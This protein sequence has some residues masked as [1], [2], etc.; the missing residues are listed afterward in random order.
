MKKY[1]SS[2]IIT[3]IIV[4]LT[5]VVGFF[6][7]REINAKNNP[8][9]QTAT[10]APAAGAPAGSLAGGAGAQAGQGT[11]RNATTVRVTP[12]ELGV[13]ENSVIINGDVL[14]SY[15]ISLYPAV[16]GRVTETRYQVGDSVNQGAVVAMV[17]PSRPGEVYSQSQVVSTIS[18]TVLSAPIHPGDTVSANSAVYVVGDLSTLIVETFVPERFSNSAQR[19]LTA[20]V[21]LEALPGETFNAVVDE[22]SPVLDPLSRTLRIRLRFAGR[23]DSR[24]KAGMF[25]TISL[26]TNT[27]QNVPVIPRTAMINTYGSWIVF[28]VDERNTAQRREITLGLESETLVE[29]TGGIEIGDRVVTAGQNFLTHGESV[30]IVD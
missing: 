28:I 2:A 9:G 3:V 21:F 22:V 11:A 12:V 27:R 14:A 13:I 17:D 10:R 8:A 15:Q 16:A 30:R 5:L 4:I 6:L 29:V 23:P 1:K 7:Y 24:I 26:V 25:A 19:G 18:G 20:Q